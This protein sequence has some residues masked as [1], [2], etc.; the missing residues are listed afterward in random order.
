MR[1]TILAL[2]ACALAAP[3]AAEPIR[4]DSGAAVEMRAGPGP[5]FPRIGRVAPGEVLDLGR[6]DL[7]GRW[8]LVS[9]DLRY[10]WV[11][12]DIMT[13]R[14]AVPP[15]PVPDVTVTP[16]PD[17][18]AAPRVEPIAPRV[19]PIAPRLPDLGGRIGLPPIAGARPPLLLSTTAPMRNVTPGVVNLRAGPGT[20]YDVV[21]RLDPGA[22]VLIEVCIPSE[23]WCRVAA[24]GGGTGWV[25]TTLIGLERLSLR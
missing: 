5:A 10:G 2:L 15:D 21:G 1:P 9:T 3:A 25:K 23:Q 4:N 17:R 7:Q 8:C 12:T 6:C 24:S 16:L 11:D 13:A 14:L 19:E 22:A 20:D 18:P